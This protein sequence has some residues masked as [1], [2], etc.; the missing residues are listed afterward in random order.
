MLFRDLNDAQRLYQEAL[1]AKLIH[2]VE[3]PGHKRS[4]FYTVGDDTVIEAA[5]PL[6]ASSA[7]GRELEQAGEGI[8]GVT[9]KT[10][11]LDRA[12]DHLR[13][14][15]IGFEREDHSL[16]INRDDAFGMVLGFTDQT[17]A[18]DSRR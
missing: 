16:I 12:A 15:D 13:A 6:A 11:N 7:A 8:F 18:N 5:Q 17:L 2:E 9:F 4:L 3:L 14:N 1:G 10:R